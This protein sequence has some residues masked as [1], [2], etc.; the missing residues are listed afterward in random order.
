MTHGWT[1]KG[2]HQRLPQALHRSQSERQ[3]KGGVNERSINIG[4]DEK[5]YV[6][7]VDCLIKEIIGMY[8]QKMKTMEKRSEMKTIPPLRYAMFSSER[9]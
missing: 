8:D 3:K 9:K 7:V 2:L 4:G 1:V 6:K 5:I